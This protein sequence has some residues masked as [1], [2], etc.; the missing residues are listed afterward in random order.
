MQSNIYMEF[1]RLQAEFTR[2]SSLPGDLSRLW[3]QSHRFRCDL[4]VDPA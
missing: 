4:P 1:T 3:S 2:S